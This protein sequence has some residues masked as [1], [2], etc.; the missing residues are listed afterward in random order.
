MYGQ[1]ITIKLNIANT[2]L[3]FWSIRLLQENTINLS[4]QNSWKYMKIQYMFFCVFLT[5]GRGDKPNFVDPFIF[6]FFVQS[7]CIYFWRVFQRPDPTQTV[8]FYLFLWIQQRYYIMPQF[9]K[10]RNPKS[11]PYSRP[12]LGF[13]RDKKYQKIFCTQISWNF[14]NFTQ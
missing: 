1:N 4:I 14:P 9:Q 5:W 6:T 13:E 11:T 7:F 12:K 8:D 10:K 3:C 2:K